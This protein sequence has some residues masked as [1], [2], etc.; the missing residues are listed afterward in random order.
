M[1]MIPPRQLSRELDGIQTDILVQTFADRI[2]VLVT[3]LGKVGNLVDIK[4]TSQ[5]MTV[6]DLSDSRYKQVCLQ[7]R[8]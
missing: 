5:F 6:I 4:F 2:L 8:L 1:A 7:R 3:Q